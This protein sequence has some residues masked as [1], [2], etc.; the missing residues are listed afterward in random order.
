MDS[1]SLQD[2][3]E[4]VAIDSLLKSYFTSWHHATPSGFH[5]TLARQERS[6]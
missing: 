1:Y 5:M 3:D 6:F 2:G 4:A